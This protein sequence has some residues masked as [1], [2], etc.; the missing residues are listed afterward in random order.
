MRGSENGNSTVQNYF[1]PIIFLS[2]RNTLLE[3]PLVNKDIIIIV[4]IRSW[5]CKFALTRNP[6][7]TTSVC[8]VHYPLQINKSQKARKKVKMHM[9]SSAACYCSL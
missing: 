1:W 3:D 6:I 4:I 2:K 8:Y 7:C 5:G 9:N